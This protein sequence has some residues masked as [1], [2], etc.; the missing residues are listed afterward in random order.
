MKI[1]N[2]TKIGLSV[3]HTFPYT[4]PLYEAYGYWSFDTQDVDVRSQCFAVVFGRAF[5]FL[6]FSFVSGKTLFAVIKV[7][8]ERTEW[9]E[10]S[11]AQ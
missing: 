5:F 1:M 9:R 3:I 4:M 6:G 10:S 11:E 2:K 8:T 7:R